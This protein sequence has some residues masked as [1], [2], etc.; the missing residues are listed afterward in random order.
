MR[1]VVAED[2]PILRAGL[3]GLLEDEAQVFLRQIDHEPG[4]EIAGRDL[5]GEVLQ[6]PALGRPGADGRQH[7]RRVQAA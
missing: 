6:L 5:R 2:S 7:R 1:I 3:V 4:G